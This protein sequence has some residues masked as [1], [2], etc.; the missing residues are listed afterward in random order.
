MINYDEL[1]P[2]IRE[3]V[4]KLN[5]AGFITTDSGDGSKY[6]DMEG[7]LP[8][9]M[10]VCKTTVE[11]L[12]LESH[13]LMSFLKDNDSRFWTVE[14]V[15]HPASMITLLIGTSPEVK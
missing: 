2:G 4:K 10:I 8:F 15:Y 14:A 12:I 3:I 6:P 5:N 1:D 9:P 13:R 11:N 7:A